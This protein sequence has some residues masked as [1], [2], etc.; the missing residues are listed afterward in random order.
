M[1]TSR[2]YQREVISSAECWLCV[3]YRLSSV[4][5]RSGSAEV[6]AAQ[7]VGSAAIL[8]VFGSAEFLDATRSPPLL[9]FEQLD[10]DRLPAG[11]RHIG[12]FFDL[13]IDEGEERLDFDEGFGQSDARQNQNEP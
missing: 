7:E 2:D 10:A 1:A 6:S 3:L 8:G 12:R 9:D 11:K 4:E 5:L 13:E